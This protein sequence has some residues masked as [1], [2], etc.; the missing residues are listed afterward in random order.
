MEL[1]EL[2]LAIKQAAYL[3]GDF[4]LSSGKK[5][6]YYLDKYLFS[7]DPTLLSEIAK[8]LARLL[9]QHFDRL[10]GVELGAVPLVAAL[11]LETG[12]PFVIVRKNVKEYGTSK[13]FEGKLE[14]GEKVVLVEDVLTTASQAIHAAARLHEFGA[15]VVKVIYV[16]DRLEGAAQNLA[17]AGLAA[18]SV[19]TK[20]DLGL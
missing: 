8:A 10:A 6:K 3:D 15:H 5:S 18:E 12:K 4:T 14:R 9:P 7:T 13:L 1:R 20:T 17:N 19:I 2:A 16:I 11:A